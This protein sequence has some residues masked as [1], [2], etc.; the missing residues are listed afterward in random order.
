MWFF[1]VA[2]SAVTLKTNSSGSPADTKTLSAGVP[3]FY[4][5][6]CGLSSLSAIFSG[7]DITTSYWTNSSSSSVANVYLNCVTSS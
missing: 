1:L 4:C 6:N 2:D 7:A 5:T 3:I